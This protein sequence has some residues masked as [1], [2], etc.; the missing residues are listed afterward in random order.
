MRPLASVD[1]E[2]TGTNVATD[3]IVSLGV[4][5]VYAEGGPQRFYD[6]FNPGIPIP[7]EAVAIHGI[8]N[9]EARKHP[10]FKQKA[11]QVFRMLQGCDLLGYNVMD[12]DLPLL[13]EELFR[14]GVEWDLSGVAVVDACS[15]FKQKNPRRLEDAVPRYCGRPHR[16]AHDALNDCEE[17]FEVFKGQLKEHEDLRKMDVKQ[18]GEF[19]RKDNR[20]DLCGRIVLNGQ[21]VPVYNI[22]K[23]KG[24]PV[25]QDPGFGNWMLKNDFPEHTKQVLR[26]I[27]FQGG[28]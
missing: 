28:R 9:E 10:P 7:D 26:R 13:W 22:G 4:L 24:T 23:A 1:L 5:K 20:V 8:T 14:A 6:V 16:G 18:L 15:I 12:F 17:T 21:G 2:T 3:R 19:C 25:D 11:G 27:L